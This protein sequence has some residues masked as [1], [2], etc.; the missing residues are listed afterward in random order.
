MNPDSVKYSSSPVEATAAES[1]LVI[2]RSELNSYNPS[3]NKFIRINL[4]VA[5]KS[6]IDW[7]D[8]VLSLKFTNMS[9]QTSGGGSA[10]NSA[11]K[12]QL[13]NMIKS[14]SV[15]NSQGEQIEYINNYNLIVNVMDDY[16]V[17]T[18]HKAGVDQ[19]LGGGSYD[20][21]PNNAIAL[22]GSASDAGATDGASKTLV[23]SLM[24]GFTS[25][26]FLL[27]LGYLVGQAPA[28]VIELEDATTALKLTTASNTVASYRVE[29][30]QVRAKQIRFNSAFNQMFEQN[31][32]E[33]GAT[34]VNYITE[35]FLHNQGS[36]TAGVQGQQNIP[37][38]VNPRSA[39]YILA[40][41]RLESG[42]TGRA[43]FSIGNRSSMAINQ[44]SWE[45]AGKLYPTQP[46][47]VSDT[48][49][50]QAYANVL[51]CL[52]QIGNTAHNTL[53]TQN[54]TANTKFYDNTQATAQKFISGLVLE[55][56]NSANNSTTYSGANLSTVGQMSFRP[57]LNADTSGA[58]RVDFFTSCD[59]SIH[60]T[61]DG[62]LYTV[63]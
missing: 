55:D 24:T 49:V 23:D 32:M 10:A 38:S 11:A 62:R 22:N 61:F 6:W 25:G 34:G 14:V 59:M 43:D 51:D 33:A 44:Y 9:Y 52:G 15:I 45:I 1:E 48:N 47:Q 21:D 53:I 2:F 18:N 5:D 8:S 17:G 7:S 37:F 42:I 46:I 35:T 28:I 31:L 13:S 19:I 36:I 56:F 26:Q 3:N 50:S 20:G 57:Q 27:P 40:V 58:Y 60:I 30:V 16:T 41:N 54:A 12:T 29:E 39:K 63:R 4:P